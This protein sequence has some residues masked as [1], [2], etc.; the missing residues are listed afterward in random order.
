MLPSFERR[1]MRFRMVIFGAVLLLGRLAAASDAGDSKSK[2]VMAPAEV[3][4][5]VDQLLAGELDLT[6]SDPAAQSSP[7]TSDGSKSD[8]ETF[9]RRV[10]LDLLG[11]S[12]S[13]ESIILFILNDDAGKRTRIIDQLLDDRQYAENWA[14][15]WRDVIFYRKTEDRA[16]IAA[17][18]CAK[19]LA[20]Q[21]YAN[22]PWD[23][24]VTAFI[25]AKGDVVENGNTG[26]I[27]AQGGKPEEVVAEISRIFIG[28][29]IQ[30]AQCHDHPTDRWKR[31]QFHELAAFFPRVAVRRDMSTQPPTFSVVVNDR[32]NNFPRRP[33]A[34]QRQIGTAEHRMP[35]KDDPSA[36]GTLMQPVFFVNGN[37]LKT[38]TKDDDRRGA[39]AQWLTAHEN[40][41]FAKAYV[42]RIWSELVGE[43]FYEPID[44]LGPDRDGTA[45]QTIDFLST[46]FAHS[47]YDVK[48]LFRTIL[49]TDAYQRPSRSRHAP[50]ETAFRSNVPQR[51]RGDQVFNEFVDIFAINEPDVPATG[52]RPF[53]MNRSPRAQ[54]N[55]VFGYDPSSPRDEITGSIP[56]ALVM[57]N[58][59]L[60]RQ[61]ID[62]NRG[63]LGSLLRQVVDN[64]ELVTELYLRTLARQPSDLE[65][66]TC[67]AYVK[68]TGNRSEAFEDIFWSLIN[69]TEFL[70]RK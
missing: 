7:S 65:L 10:T 44:D 68:D 2:Y 62:S 20:D 54:F 8:D 6:D 38:G 9:L 50:D 3:A 39:L 14:R 58:H 46:E 25:T 26:L 55:A 64:D 24:I 5:R 42:N 12:P 66:Q 48:W 60:V 52:M 36:Q 27:M 37:R 16:G 31:E 35:D 67:R 40:P 32:E 15:Y 19:F 23:Q 70:H 18:S 34:N 13:P 49:A 21:F 53:A 17:E 45:P 11:R 4:R 69:S 28:I 61:G 22:S 51:L 41:W 33:N 29:Q 56:Q 47:G 59:N 43:G 1:P 57:M 63:V 30:C